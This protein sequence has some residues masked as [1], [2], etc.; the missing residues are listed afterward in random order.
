MSA[1]VAIIV[2]AD[3]NWAIGKGNSLLYN[4]P[5]D[6]HFFKKMTTNNTVV[7][8]LNT[9]NSLPNGKPLPNRKN[10]VLAPQKVDKEGVITAT[11]FDELKEL[12]SQE[13]ESKT[14]FICG[15]M[16]VYEQA[17]QEEICDYAYVT[18]I[19][20]TTEDADAFFPN[21]NKMPE[22]KKAEEIGDIIDEVSNIKIKFIK[23][24][25]EKS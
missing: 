11:S 19:Y 20:A 5:T 3:E 13:D 14:V 12:I 2:A 21:L 24:V 8:G 22:W 6:M 9:L 10:I 16:S 18:K 17:I 4:I 1:K 7:F 25:R 15:G 23:Y